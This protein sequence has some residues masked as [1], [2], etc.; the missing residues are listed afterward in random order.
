MSR[1]PGPLLVVALASCAT[2]L[3]PPPPSPAPPSGEG[4]TL[5]PDP[6]PPAPPPK[7]APPPTQE[8]APEPKPA[9]EPDDEYSFED[10]KGASGYCYHTIHCLPP[11]PSGPAV[12]APAP[13]ES[14][15]ATWH[16]V[17]LHPGFSG[18]ES[19]KMKR[20]LCCYR[21]TTCETPF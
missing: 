11:P 13:H 16:K 18:E 14:C 10:F 5:E 19:K 6:P 20:T 9:P 17:K 12:A 1:M 3:P 8:A 15:A 7:P 4:K 2:T 21:T